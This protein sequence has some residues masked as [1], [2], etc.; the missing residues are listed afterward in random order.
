MCVQEGKTQGALFKPLMCGGQRE[1]PGEWM[2][3]SRRAGRFH[4]FHT[5]TSSALPQVKFVGE[6]GIDEGGVQK[7][8]F[9]LLVGG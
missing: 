5:C 4:T 9:Q 6:E 7:E 2:A 3:G 8:F 1:R